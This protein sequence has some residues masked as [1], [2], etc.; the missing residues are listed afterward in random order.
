ML[1]GAAAA[2]RVWVAPE[3]PTPGVT[4]VIVCGPNPL[5]PEKANGPTPPLLTFVTAMVGNLPLVKVQAIFDPG[6]VE[7]ES[8]TT[9]C[10]AKLGVAT[11]PGPNPVQSID[12]RV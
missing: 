12:V 7:A 9:D 3:T 11:P 6:A 4:V 8:K 2:V 5:F 10:V 1:V